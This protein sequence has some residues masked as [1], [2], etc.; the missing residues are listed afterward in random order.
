MLLLV[1]L[2]VP[3]LTLDLNNTKLIFDYV[4]WQ[5]PE[6]IKGFFHRVHEKQLLR[7]GQYPRHGKPRQSGQDRDSSQGSSPKQA[8]SFHVTDSEDEAY[9]TAEEEAYPT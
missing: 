1:K 9:F 8:V 6:D 2:Q 3:N 7:F 4:D 5:T